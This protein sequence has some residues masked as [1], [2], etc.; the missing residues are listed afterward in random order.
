MSFYRKARVVSYEIQA[1]LEHAHGFL[2]LM[3]PENVLQ[4]DATDGLL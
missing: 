2:L 3:V 4:D 1:L